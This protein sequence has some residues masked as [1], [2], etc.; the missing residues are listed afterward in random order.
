MITLRKSLES[1]DKISG[2]ASHPNLTELETVLKLFLAGRMTSTEL[3]RVLW[4]PLVPLECTPL[5]EPAVQLWHGAVTNLA[6]YQF[7]DMERSALER[8]FELLIESVRTTGKVCL[9]PITTS[10][11]IVEA[12]KANTIPSPLDPRHFNSITVVRAGNEDA[13]Q[14]ELPEEGEV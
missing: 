5:R 6:F 8:S 1:V 9:T 12:L 3:Q 4:G 14:P 13:V 2:M 10:P 7:C 11:C